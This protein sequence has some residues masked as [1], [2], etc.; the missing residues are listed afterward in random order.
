MGP[1]ESRSPKNNDRF[2]QERELL[3]SSFRRTRNMK[4]DILKTGL[5]NPRHGNRVWSDKS[6]SYC[7]HYA[8]SRDDIT[9]DFTLLLDS[10]RSK[11]RSAGLFEALDL[12]RVHLAAKLEKQVSV[13]LLQV[14]ARLG[15]AIDLRIERGLVGGCGVGKLRHLRFRL[16]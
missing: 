1:Y 6:A 4:A 7:G 11:T 9:S 16:L 10:A 2:H 5:P 3:K 15:D 14:R 8:D 13:R 12:V